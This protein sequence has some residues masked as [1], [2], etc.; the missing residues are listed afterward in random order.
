MKNHLTII[1]IFLISISF[2]QS[3]IEIHL[4]SDPGVNYNGQTILDTSTTPSFNVYM[5]VVNKTNADLEVLFR[6]VI[7]SSDVDFYDQFCDQNLCHSCSGQDWTSPSETP[8][9]ISPNDSSLMK[10]QG[11][12]LD[13]GTATIR[14]YII[15]NSNSE[16]LDSV[17]LSITYNSVTGNQITQISNIV[18]YP[19]PANQLFNVDVQSE[20][21]LKLILFSISGKKVYETQLYQGNNQL[22]LDNL[23]S[24]MFLYSIISGEENIKTKRL[25]VK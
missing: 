3:E 13:E 8:I 20:N 22:N 12:F 9:Q 19:N 11:T 1:F 21:N 5:R 6:R 24:G 18:E 4:D 10:P 17:D 7:K 2:A 16:I 15:D 23:N 14:Y 25:I